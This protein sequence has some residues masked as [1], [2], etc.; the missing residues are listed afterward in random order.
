MTMALQSYSARHTREPLV[1]SPPELLMRSADAGELKRQRGARVVTAAA[2][3]VAVWFHVGV[4]VDHL[5]EVPY[6]GWSFVAF[7]VLAAGIAG[8]LLLE[9]RTVVWCAALAL[10]VATLALYTVSRTV[11]L[12][13]A[14]DDIGD[15]SNTAGIICGIAEIVVTLIAAAVLI[16]RTHATDA[17][18]T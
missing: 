18:T 13:G 3:A 17:T 11:G 8:S 5:E 4:A 9:S 10:S 12:P 2:L 15:W 14:G 7:I 6:L 16:R 1:V